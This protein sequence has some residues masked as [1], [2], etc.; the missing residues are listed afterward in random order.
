MKG[1]LPR[2]A[3]ARGSGSLGGQPR[4]WGAWAALAVVGVAALNTGNNS[5]YLLFS[6]ALGT[7][8]SGWVVAA[9][10]LRALRV[11]ARCPTDASAGSPTVLLLDIAN[12]SRWLPTPCLLCTVEGLPGRAAV[13]ALE[14]GA[15]TTLALATVFPRRGRHPLPA[16][17]VEALLPIPF[18]RRRARYPQR[19]DVVVL[20]RR[21]SVGAVRLAQ[22]AK[23]DANGTG[24]RG[25]RGGEVAHLREFRPGDDRRDIHWKQT[26]RQQWLVVVERQEAPVAAEYVVLDRQ[27]PRRD[28][29]VWRERFE[30]L[31]AEAAAA[32]CA[33]VRAGTTVG[34]V[35]GGT[36]LPP[37]RGVTHGRRLLRALALVE[38][39]GPGEDPL[40]AAVR[41]GQ[42]YR[43][44][45]GR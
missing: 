37:G 32:V 28:D 14:R 31:V 9:R 33:R 16:V 30:D 23:A 17:W 2:R 19:G 34:L 26:A 11:T 42:V 38:A 3:S 25:Q 7:V 10:S 41:S 29:P 1:S 5:L 12:T 13:A 27:L 39:A 36:V 6:L 44:A 8:L 22:V 45:G 43:L 15:R 24:G 35:M 21:V 18:L 40:P 20:P 4:V